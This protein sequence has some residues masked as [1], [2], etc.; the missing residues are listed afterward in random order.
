MQYSR[1]RRAR[2]YSKPAGEINPESLQANP[3]TQRMLQEYFSSMGQGSAR[4]TLAPGG[5]RQSRIRKNSIDHHWDWDAHIDE[6]THYTDIMRLAAQQLF[7]LNDGI[8]DTVTRKL[9]NQNIR[10]VA[11]AIET[12]RIEWL[13][14]RWFKSNLAEG[15]AHKEKEGYLL[16]DSVGRP[17]PYHSGLAAAIR[18]E[19]YNLPGDINDP[20]IQAAMVKF[21]D[22]I[23]AAARTLDQADALNVA[24]HLAEFMDWYEVPPEE[25]D[26]ESGDG[27]GSGTGTGSGSGKGNEPDKE[28]G[29]G[30]GEGSGEGRP[31]GESNQS[32]AGSTN[33]TA[34][35]IQGGSG[36][37][38]GGQ[39]AVN[40]GTVVPEQKAP[41]KVTEAEMRS[42]AQAI[43]KRIVTNMKRTKTRRAKALAESQSRQANN[44]RQ[45]RTHGQV[46]YA[47]AGNEGQFDA[48]HTAEQLVIPSIPVNV[49]EHT[50][51]AIQQYMNNRPPEM[52][53]LRRGSLAR[54]HAWKLNQGSVKVFRR[55]PK[56]RGQVS[57]LVD[58]SG[59]MGCWCA[60]CGNDPDMYTAG[61]FLAWQVAGAL[62]QIHP[63]A[64][65]YGFTSLSR[66]VRATI[67][68]FP[69]GHMPG[70][71]AADREAN[72]ARGTPIMGGTPTCTAMLW[73]KEHIMS[74]PAD[75]TAIIITDGGPDPC[76][77]GVV[78]HVEAIGTEMLSSG[79]KF[80]TV[81]IGDGQYIN[82]P[83]EV[84]VNISEVGDLANIQTLLEAID[85]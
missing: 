26:S 24:V 51:L 45:V 10:A 75:T 59:S 17:R 9:T 58:M 36:G 35:P 23:R 81:F 76:G 44:R 83:T 6:G 30:A 1:R 70:A 8:V 16:C 48:N 40:N 49:S 5:S 29:N 14:D 3:E 68:P 4:V 22:E 31:A 50:Q 54:T 38:S 69:A 78:S 72:D 61:S 84:S 7:S 82:M 43:S 34:G 73:F 66:N 46:S 21:G 27:E 18:K 12:A 80:G 42:N 52:Q 37:R 60:K 11:S 15:S 71:C 53:L 62:S 28:G 32:G 74:R 56:T 79:I 64:E 47:A 57:I 2:R 67:L 63:T 55:P 20:K 33:T 25:Q 85:K 77:N 39:P 41:P 19:L 13:A 65:V